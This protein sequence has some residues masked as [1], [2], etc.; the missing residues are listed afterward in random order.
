MQ[1][2]TTTWLD[3]A[4]NLV[5]LVL[6]PVILTL[7]YQTNT[8]EE[9]CVRRR[10]TECDLKWT[11]DDKREENDDGRQSSGEEDLNMESCG[12]PPSKSPPP[13]Q[14]LRPHNFFLV[15]YGFRNGGANSQT[16]AVR[17]VLRSLNCGSV[18]DSA[19]RHCV[20]R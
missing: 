5:L 12:P 6:R 10:R 11:D 14:F 17:V 9:W 8:E 18:Q 4:S 3:L 7:L 16:W 13:P 2:R 19:L 15:F 20:W 1:G